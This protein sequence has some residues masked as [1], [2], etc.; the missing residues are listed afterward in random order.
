MVLST[1]DV[2]G[3]ALSTLST[4]GPQSVQKN[5]SATASAE[6][7]AK[8]RTD[9]DDYT[10]LSVDLGYR[11]SKKDSMRVLQ[12][13][14]KYQ[15]VPAGDEEFL[16]NDT[17]IQYTRLLSENYGGFDWRLRPAFTLPTSRD[18]GRQ[19]IVSRPSLML[20]IGHK[21]FHGRMNVS[22]R[23][24]Y[25]YQ[26]NRYQTRIDG[27]PLREHMVSNSLIVSYSLSQAWS[28]MVMGV[29]QYYWDQ[30]S[31]YAQE[32]VRMKGV[33]SWIAGI[34]Y[35]VNETISLGLNYVQSDAFW[36]EGRY[37]VNVYDPASSRVSF[38]LSLSF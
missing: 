36:K 29:A 11:F 7:Y 27:R 15:V 16:L 12:T 14:T 18:S 6:Y 10:D 31:P 34:E 17:T 13:A 9:N 3:A 1:S 37:D 35:A 26:I 4:T 2:A 28:A 20:M 33:Y 5:W 19:G 21:F 22:Y 38:A 25:L 8:T 23:P 32:P 30:Q 24:S